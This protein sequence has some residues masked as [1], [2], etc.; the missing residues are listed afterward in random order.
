[1]FD[2]W[3]LLLP[4][5]MLVSLRVS[6]ALAI[7]PAPLGSVAPTQVRAALGVILAI[8]L[9]L[10]RLEAGSLAVQEPGWL[11]AA[12]LTEALSL[13]HIPEPTRPY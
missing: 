5:V 12:A 10:P 8:A 1:M 13:I 11:G 6:V 9:R 4:Y 2:S 3:V 7:L